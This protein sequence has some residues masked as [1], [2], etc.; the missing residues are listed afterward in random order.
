[1]HLL[2]L[3]EP[4]GLGKTHGVL[5]AGDWLLEDRN[6]FEIAYAAPT[7]SVQ[8]RNSGW[9]PWLNPE[10]DTTLIMRSGAI[11]DLLRLTPAIAAWKAKTGRKVALSCFAAH[12]PIFAGTGVVDELVPYPL[13]FNRV[14]HFR[15][16]I[17]LEEV[18]EMDHEN[19][20]TDVF[21]KA[22]GVETPLEDYKP[23]YK[24]TDEEKEATKKYLFANRTNVALQ[25]R[26][27]VKNRDYPASLWA[28]V[29]LKLEAHG[30]GVLLLGKKGQ[31][32][33][34]P[35][36]LQTPFIRD[37]SQE[38]LSLRESVAVLAQCDAFAGVDSSMLHFAAALEIPSVGLFGPFRWDTRTGK[39]PKTIALNGVGE[40]AGCGWHMK[41]FV[42]FPP[43]KPCSQIGVC[44]VLAGIDPK[45]VVTKIDLL[46]P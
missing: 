34:L 32:P 30:W 42:H 41:N 28:Q 1:V 14:N 22:L 38:D 17:T 20:I 40:C 19:H 43:N 15:E 36:Q 24:V 5:E 18:M 9:T 7:K 31:I 46:K 4:I 35:P 45:R 16:I 23:L 6:A 11:G 39:D 12:H 3:L 37:L 8:L 10:S 2:N 21:A 25:P 29:M 44:V 26:A 13:P 33:P 27:S